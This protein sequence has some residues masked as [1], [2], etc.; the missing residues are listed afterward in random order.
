MEHDAGAASQFLDKEYEFFKDEYNDEKE[1]FL[2][3]SFFHKD[4]ETTLF[5]GDWKISYSKTSF[6]E[7]YYWVD[8]YKGVSL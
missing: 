7:N 6:D 4:P 3:G 1:A 5:S 8:L 2:I